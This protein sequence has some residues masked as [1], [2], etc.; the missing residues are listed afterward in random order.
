M[1]RGGGG[2]PFPP[3]PP[4]KVSPWAH[5]RS[6]SCSAAVSRSMRN[7]SRSATSRAQRTSSATPGQ[8]TLTAVYSGDRDFLPSI[9]DPVTFTIP[10]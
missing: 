2:D 1:S 8:H 7:R 9:S 6:A 5:S 4:S 3:V 10:G